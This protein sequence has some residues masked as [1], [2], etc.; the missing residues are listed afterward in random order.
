MNGRIRGATTVDWGGEWRTAQHHLP[1]IARPLT[2]GIWEN[3]WDQMAETYGTHDDIDSDFV[4]KVTGFLL[5]EGI[6]KKDDAVLDVGCGPGTHALDLAK[7]VA[8]MTCLDSSPAML[9]SLHERRVRTGQNNIQGLLG[10]WED[11]AEGPQYDLVFSSFCPALNNQEMLLKME[12]FSRRHCCYIAI[13]DSLRSQTTYDLWDRLGEPHFSNVGYDIV[14]PFNLLYDLERGPSLKVFQIAST[15]CAP[16]EHMV[17][18]QLSYFRMFMEVDAP[19]ES[20]IRAYVEEGA[21]GGQY[22]REN[23]RRFGLLYWEVE[24]F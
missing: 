7:H 16:V 19:V 24:G 5:R 12:R 2:P 23:V 8:S 6:L 15:Y 1:H 21:N 10:R 17:Q 14:Y 4:K 3:Y 22:R 9:R 20:I 18:N 11:L 13:S